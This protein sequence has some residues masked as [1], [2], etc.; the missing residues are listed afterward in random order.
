MNQYA[1]IYV[2]A[3]KINVDLYTSIYRCVLVF[4]YLAQKE[5]QTNKYYS[6]FDL[7]DSYITIAFT[8]NM[9]AI[10]I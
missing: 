5:A 8:D 2:V 7:L 1:D 3:D 9:F 4:E 6:N 10:L